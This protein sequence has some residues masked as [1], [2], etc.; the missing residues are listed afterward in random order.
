MTTKIQQILERI[1]KLKES[2]QHKN[3]LLSEKET[4]IGKLQHKLDEQQ[5]VIAAHEE[6]LAKLNERLQET[7]HRNEA[8]NLA[9]QV[10]ALTKAQKELFELRMKVRQLEAD[11][12]LHGLGDT[13]VA[14]PAPAADDTEKAELMAVV[15]IQQEQIQDLENQL[16]RAKAMA[17]TRQAG[18]GAVDPALLTQWRNDLLTATGLP[19]PPTPLSSAAEMAGFLSAFRSTLARLADDVRESRE[20]DEVILILQQQVDDAEAAEATEEDQVK[21]LQAQVAELTQRLALATGDAGT[22]D[23]ELNDLRA[24]V[25]ALMIELGEKDDIIAAQQMQLTKLQGS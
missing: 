4:L 20:K 15:N 17:A 11:R 21:R 1:E 10:E 2:L 5:R 6:A 19:V 3:A 24:Q 12:K 23:E 22:R 14:E 16:E 25:A 8:L 18:A 7:S 9:E 13:A